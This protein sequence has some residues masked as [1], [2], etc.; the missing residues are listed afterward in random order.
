[1]K[2]C[3]RQPPSKCSLSKT[4]R[5]LVELMQKMNF[6]RIERLYIRNGEPHFE[7]GSRI[8]RDVVFG[9]N[10][11]PNP[12]RNREDFLLKDQICELFDLCDRERSFVIENLIIQN[13]LPV[14]MTVMN[15]AA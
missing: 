8:L 15:G 3:V 9:K 7:S 10:N 12:A 13:G 11:S 2:D 4:R 14:R 1:M 6:G 5:N